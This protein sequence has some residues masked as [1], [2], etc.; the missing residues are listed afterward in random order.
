MSTIDTLLDKAINNGDI[1][2]TIDEPTREIRYTGELLL[3][4]EGDCQA[5]KIYFEAPKIVGNFIDLQAE[6]TLIYVDFKNAEGEPYFIECGDREYHEDTDT[7]SFSWLLT[8]RVTVEK[9]TVKFRVCVKT[10]EDEPK[11]W[12]T[13]IFTGKILEGINVEGK[14]PEIVPDETITTYQLI[15][16]IKALQARLAD[17][18]KYADSVVN[19]AITSKG[20][21]TEDAANAT[22]VTQAEADT[23]VTKTEAE[24]FVTQEE[25]DADK[26]SISDSI[27]TLNDEITSL[28]SDLS[29]QTA[30][31][32][33]KTIAGTAPELAQDL[34]EY[35]ENDNI[36]ELLIT[37][38]T[39]M[40]G[41]V[42]INNNEFTLGSISK[43]VTDDVTYTK[44]VLNKT[45]NHMHIWDVGGNIFPTSVEQAYQ[46]NHL[47]ITQNGSSE[48]YP[49]FSIYGR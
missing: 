30:Y 26:K 20:Y 14:S 43:Q 34:T 16:E 23:H 22:F 38:R 5:E 33:L 11:E 29:N 10:D 27:S 28:S 39:T 17:I 31:T 21:I 25:L 12:H 47:I 41:E 35:L 2:L 7:V 19:N 13:S 6:S 46:Y 4:V 40:G 45:S 48:D 15:E 44:I 32:C 18:E 42:I 36:H 37:V 24:N 3:G 9:G 8:E 49:S 1:V